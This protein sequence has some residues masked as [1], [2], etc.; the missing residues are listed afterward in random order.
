[1]DRSTFEAADLV[2]D[3]IADKL[4]E[5]LNS[6]HFALIRVLLARLSE[7]VGPRYSANL[8]VSVDVFHAERLNALPLLTL[9]LSASEGKTPY[10]TTGDSTPQ[11]YVVDGE[12]QIAPHDRCPKCYGLWN[13]KLDHPTCLVC[14]ATMGKE[15]KLLL[16]ND[17]CYFCEEGKVSLTAP[18]CDNC[19]QQIYPAWVVWG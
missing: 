19:G 4:D 1:M 18:E 16:D 14:G 12:I 8:H 9:G 13:F 15:V 10:K 11:K 7:K 6:D 2:V 5:L 17:V 3:E